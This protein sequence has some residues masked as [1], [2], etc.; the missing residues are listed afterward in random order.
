MLAFHDF[1]NNSF[2]GPPTAYVPLGALLPIYFVQF[3]GS[4]KYAVAFDLEF[5]S[6]VVVSNHNLLYVFP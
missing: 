2:V 5:L 1:M 6:V 4:H 3:A